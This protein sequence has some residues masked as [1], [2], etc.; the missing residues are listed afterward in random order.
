M[1]S[2]FNIKK[3]YKTDQ[4]QSMVE[5]AIVL[6]VLLL[7]LFAIFEFGRILGA[8]MLINDLARDGVRYGVVGVSDKNIK[9]NIME[10]DSFLSI[11][12]ANIK[13]TPSS[14][15]IGA[16]LKVRLDY[17][18]DIITPIISSVVPNPMQ[19]SAEYV[20]RVEKLP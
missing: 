5:M 14:R 18:M 9:D 2:M 3:L 12:S 1:I 10:N 16:S 6:P 20:M 4:G 11:T 13:I 8:Y 17:E 19:L 15:T 7:I